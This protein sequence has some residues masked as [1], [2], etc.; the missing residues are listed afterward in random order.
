MS[1][2]TLKIFDLESILRTG[3]EAL[4]KSELNSDSSKAAALLVPDGYRP[5]VSLRH[6]DGRKIKSSAAAWNFDPLADHIDIGFE[7]I[8]DPPVT[9]VSTNPPPPFRP[10]TPST[11]QMAPAV[12][13]VAVG[14]A[15]VTALDKKQ[16]CDALAEA[17][18]S[19]LEFIGLKRFLTYFLPAKGFAWSKKPESCRAVLA[20]VI[21]SN[22]VET[23]KV[24]NPK[25]PDFPTTAIRLIRPAA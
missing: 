15:E 6:R 9:G 16:F 10:L 12:A 7:K 21:D 24:P 11:P 14:P 1:N 5:V 18:R 19:S 13:S 22:E 3:L 20:K 4:E 25:S 17:E 23:Y 2:K 8:P